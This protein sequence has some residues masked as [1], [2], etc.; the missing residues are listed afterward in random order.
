MSDYIAKV[1]QQTADL[2]Y[3][4]AVGNCIDFVGRIPDHG[5]EIVSA[6]EWTKICFEILQGLKT[7]KKSICKTTVNTFG[8]IAKAIGPQHV[9]AT[10]LNNLKM[11]ERQNCACTAV[12]IAIVGETCSPF[13]ILPALTNKY[14][15]SEQCFRSNV[16]CSDSILTDAL[17]DRD[18]I[19]RQTLASTVKHMVLGLAGLTCE[20][21]LIYWLNY[22]SP[23]ILRHPHTL[24]AAYPVL[25]DEK[26]KIFGRPELTMFI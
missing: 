15:V 9:L 17:V 23:N 6:T 21:A 16:S 22:V 3:R 14:Q 13:T 4:I 25:E 20:N 5:A 8:Y 7:H 2:I 24:V 12:G 11:Q 19:H 1:R 26:S 18:L 10:L